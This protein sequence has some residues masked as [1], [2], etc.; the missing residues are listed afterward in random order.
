MGTKHALHPLTTIT[1]LVLIYLFAY[2][3][4]YISHEYW[5]DAIE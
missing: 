4:L 3:S 5:A 2:E 1:I